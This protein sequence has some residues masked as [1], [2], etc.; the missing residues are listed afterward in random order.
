MGSR[1]KPEAARLVCSIRLLSHLTSPVVFISEL[2]DITMLLWEKPISPFLSSSL[3]FSF[4]F[5]SVWLQNSPDYS[6]FTLLPLKR[7]T[8]HMVLYLYH[9][10]SLK[11]HGLKYYFCTDS[12]LHWYHPASL[13]LFLFWLFYFEILRHGLTIM[14]RLAWNFQSSYF[15]LLSAG[16]AGRYCY[17]WLLPTPNSRFIWLFWH[18]IFMHCKHFKFNKFKNDI[19]HTTPWTYW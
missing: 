19:T 1:D 2:F 6:F 3:L 5:F 15:S 13:S 8:Y 16:D 14:A 10:W 9:R 11:L 4:F 17:A 18:V 12:L 7:Y